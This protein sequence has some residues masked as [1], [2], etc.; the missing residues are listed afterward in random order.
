LITPK[1]NALVH[2]FWRIHPKVYRWTEGRIGGS[3]M[4]MP[5]L[6][7]TTRGRKTGQRRAKAL[8][9]LP[10]GKDF[11]VVA[12]NLGSPSHPAWWLNLEAEPNASVQVGRTQQSVRAREAIGEERGELW[13]AITERQ[14]AYNEYQAQTSRRIPVVVLETQ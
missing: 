11:V 3:I 10:R 14:P 13:Q 8:M 5:V 4:G 12:S 1:R 7:L 9:Y 6:L 2:L